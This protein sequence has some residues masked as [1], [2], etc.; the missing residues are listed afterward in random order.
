MD[1]WTYVDMYTDGDR[2]ADVEMWTGG[3]LWTIVD[4]YTNVD[5]WTDVNLFW[6]IMVEMIGIGIKF[7]YPLKYKRILLFF[8]LARN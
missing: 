2:W 8:S 6:R 1:R 4:R 5:R 3:Q 7:L